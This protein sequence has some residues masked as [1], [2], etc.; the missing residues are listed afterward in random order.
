VTSGLGIGQPRLFRNRGDWT[1]ED[2]THPAGFGGKAG[3]HTAAWAD[4]D[5]DGR[6]DLV[7]ANTD[8]SDLSVLLGQPQTRLEGR[9]EGPIPT[10]AAPTSIVAKDL[11]DDGRVDIAWVSFSTDELHVR[12]Q[13]S[14]GL[15][16]PAVGSPFSIDSQTVSLAGG[17]LDGDA[18]GRGEDVVDRGAVSHRLRRLRPSWACRGNT[19]SSTSRPGNP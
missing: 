14:Q 6:M 8:S 11:D 12:L 18:G 9:A 2:V 10:P 1:F 7:T 17:D 5:G 16:L 4:V 13:D 15:M 19:D 3:S